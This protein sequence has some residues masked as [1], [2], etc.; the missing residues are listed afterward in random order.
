MSVRMTGG[1]SGNRDDALPN[2]PSSGAPQPVLDTSG[3]ATQPGVVMTGGSTGNRD[4]S[5]LPDV[6]TSG[7]VPEDSTDVC[8]PGAHR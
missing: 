2:V 5:S 8:D 4:A 7:T 1:N 3:N 6:P